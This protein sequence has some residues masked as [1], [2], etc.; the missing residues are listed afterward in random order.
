MRARGGCSLLT[1]VCGWGWIQ[2][3]RRAALAWR[4]RPFTLGDRFQVEARWSLMP[5]GLGVVDFVHLATLHGTLSAT[6]HT[7]DGDAVFG[8]KLIEIH[9]LATEV[10]DVI[11]FVAS[12]NLVKFKCGLS[13]A[14]KQ[15]R[16][17]SGARIPGGSTNNDDDTQN[18]YCQSLIRRQRLRVN[19]GSGC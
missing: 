11:V 19:F 7:V 9:V 6:S 8:K 5:G 17:I 2:G 16:R 12:R 13:Y 4:G 14:P 18:R 10:R 1:G 15:I 3:V